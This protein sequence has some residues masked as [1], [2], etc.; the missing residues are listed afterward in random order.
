M[1]ICALRSFASLVP[2][3][4]AVDHIA[5]AEDRQLNTA[6]TTPVA[7][8]TAATTEAKAAFVFRGV[9]YFQRWAQ[10]DQCEFTPTGQENLEK[11]SDMITINVYPSAHD[12]D[13]LAMKANV[14]ENYKSHGGRCLNLILSLARQTGLQSIL[15]LLFL[16]DQILS[17]RRLPVSS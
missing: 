8:D 11:W 14:L 17:R 10:D 15:S 6:G 16:V 4:L 7:A 3:S 9:S 2:A 13:T 1:I 12:G 5:I